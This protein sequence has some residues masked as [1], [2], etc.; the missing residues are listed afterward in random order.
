MNQ[1]VLP[2]TEK[3]TI[4]WLNPLLSSNVKTNTGKRFL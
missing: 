3:S 2:Y 4:L 1:K